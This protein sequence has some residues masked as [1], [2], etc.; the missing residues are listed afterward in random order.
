MLRERRTFMSKCKAVLDSKKVTSIKAIKR[1]TKKLII[2]CFES[3]YSAQPIQ[4][5]TMAI[6]GLNG[7][8]K[9]NG[10]YL[11]RMLK[12]NYP[13][14]RV[15]FIHKKNARIPGDVD[16][17]PR[18]SI[19]A[20]S[21]IFRSKVLFVESWERYPKRSDR[22][23]IQLWHGTPIKK[24]LFDTAEPYIL[25]RSPKHRSLQYRQILSWDYFLCDSLKA[26]DFFNSCFL[27]EDNKMLV[28]GYP[29]VK[30]LIDNSKN[31]RLR[32]TIRAALGIDDNEK[33]ITYFPTWRDY[34]KRK[35]TNN[36][37]YLLNKEVLIE[38]LNDTSLYK[39]YSSSHPYGKKPTNVRQ[40]EFDTQELILA[41]DWVV[42]D[43][44]SVIFDAVAIDIPV[45][46]L[47]KDREKYEMA[48]GLYKEVTDDLSFCTAESEAELAGILNNR[49]SIEKYRYVRDKYCQLTNKFSLME[50]LSR[51][52]KLHS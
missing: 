4:D 32:A 31:N 43:Y 24:M 28:S 39:L 11:Y 49:P 10:K 22:L 45:A 29:R 50:D 3:A 9:G 34:E 41:S 36:G 6:M 38:L 35:S 17:V 21:L 8:W 44:S 5:R 7:L 20:S 33:L 30:Y 52:L 12:I 40:H 14:W 23:V 26:K 25:K 46:L 15:V 13:D 1:K 2:S 47:M 51:V 19:Q 48:R 16:A 42:S 37:P 18:G 27:I